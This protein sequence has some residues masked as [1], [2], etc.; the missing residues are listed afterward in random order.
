M[1]KAVFPSVVLAKAP[2][3]AISERVTRTSRPV[4]SEGSLWFFSF[5]HY[6]QLVCP[7]KRE[8]NASPKYLLVP[9]GIREHCN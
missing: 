7:D 3:A 6:A 1:T 5:P 9:G 8:Y 2:C 4:P